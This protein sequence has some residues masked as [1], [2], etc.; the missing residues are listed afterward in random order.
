VSAWAALCARCG[1]GALDWDAEDAADLYAALAA[2]DAA[3][4]RRH[5]EE[6]K[7]LK[8]KGGR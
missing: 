6:A 3:E 5:A 2:A 8:N 7:R 4:A 1:A